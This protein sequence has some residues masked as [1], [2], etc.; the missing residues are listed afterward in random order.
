MT[1]YSKLDFPIIVHEFE[2]KFR[3]PFDVKTK[4]WLKIL[5]IHCLNCPHVLSILPSDARNILNYKEARA[6]PHR[7]TSQLLIVFQISNQFW[8]SALNIC[9][10]PNSKYVS[11]YRKSILL[12]TVKVDLIETK[13]KNMVRIYNKCPKIKI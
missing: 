13:T 6:L 2:L 5:E 8:V 1:T 10:N 9:L 11:D 3:Y 12:W 7:L 4:N